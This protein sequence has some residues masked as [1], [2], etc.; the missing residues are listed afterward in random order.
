MREFDPLSLRLLIATCE[1]RNIARAAEA[2]HMVPSAV[3]KR[4]SQLEEVAGVRLLERGP[5]GVRPTPAG[6]TLLEHARAML[7]SAD[8]AARDMAAFAAGVRGKVRLLASISSMAEFLPDD[9]AAF[10]QDPLHRDIQV[11]IEE[12]LSSD[13]PR[14]LHAGTAS[15]GICWDTADLRGLQTRHYRSDHLA[16]VAHPSHSL[17]QQVAVAFIDT[18]DFDHVGLP[19][20]TA[21]HAL[22]ARAAAMAGRTMHYRALLST[23]EAVLRVIRANLGIS[24][25]PIEIAEPYAT[26]LGLRVIPLT[27]AWALRRFAI[28]YR[29]EDSLSPPARL[30]L[31]HLHKRAVA[32]ETAIAC[33]NDHRAD[34]EGDVGPTERATATSTS[35]PMSCPGN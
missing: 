31:E 10:M 23:F 2:N 12:A 30:L 16:I 21:G 1:T 8:R 15:M 17:A 14:A 13:I 6:E 27:D 7:G 9:V 4:L 26:A 25:A 19:S 22:L 5:R 20:A 29:D 24:V 32:A 28:S 33:G 11:D 18:L 3:S 35:I 34:R